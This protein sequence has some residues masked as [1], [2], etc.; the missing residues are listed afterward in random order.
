MKRLPLRE[1]AA[2]QRFGGLQLRTAPRANENA[3][4]DLS[5]LKRDWI[6]QTLHDSY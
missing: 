4:Q 1:Y 5:S 2:A 6:L 3:P